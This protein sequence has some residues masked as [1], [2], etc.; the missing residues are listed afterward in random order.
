MQI[1]DHLKSIIINTGIIYIIE[2]FL[3]DIFMERF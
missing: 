1:S 2:I 3:R